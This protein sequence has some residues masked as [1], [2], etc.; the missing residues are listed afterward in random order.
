MLI[1]RKILPCVYSLFIDE[2]PMD[3]GIPPEIQAIKERCSIT[4]S[5]NETIE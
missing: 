5:G 1:T 3:D 4:K 2:A